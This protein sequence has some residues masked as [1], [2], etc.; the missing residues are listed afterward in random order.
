MKDPKN[1]MAPRYAFYLAQS[2]KDVAT[3][4]LVVREGE[5]ELPPERIQEAVKY[6]QKAL[7]AY[8]RRVAM[9]NYFDEVFVSLLEIGKLHEQ[10][11]SGERAIVDTY[12]KAYEYVPYRGAEPLYYLAK[13]FRLKNRFHLAYLYAKVGVTIAQPQGLFVDFDIYAWRIW[14]ELAVAAFF[15]GQFAEAY[16]INKELL[17]HGGILDSEAPRLEQN[18]RASKERLEAMGCATS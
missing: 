18:M 11:K 17:E 10:L 1:P 15:T 2:Y 12:I 8:E 5:N 7:K 4:L 14:D 9:G 3:E 6:R 13:Y 16:E